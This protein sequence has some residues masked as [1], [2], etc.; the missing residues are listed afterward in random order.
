[1]KCSRL[2]D[3]E[4]I[5]QWNMLHNPRLDLK[6]EAKTCFHKVQFRSAEKNC[7]M[8]TRAHRS[9]TTMSNGL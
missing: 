4:E 1:M 7:A 2:K 8:D 3:T 6:L 5:W 9:T